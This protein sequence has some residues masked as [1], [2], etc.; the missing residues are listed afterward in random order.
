MSELEYRQNDGQLD[1]QTRDE[2]DLI[3]EQTYEEYQAS[4]EALAYAGEGEAYLEDLADDPET[5]IAQR[6]MLVEAYRRQGLGDT[7]IAA[8]LGVHTSTVWGDLDFLRQQS[9]DTKSSALRLRA[10]WT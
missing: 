4:T 9:P 5:R 6:R 8:A 10:K 7:A 3:F 1:S 2:G